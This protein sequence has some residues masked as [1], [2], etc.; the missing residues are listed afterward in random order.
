MR[1]FLLYSENFVI[2]FEISWFDRVAALNS[3]ELHLKNILIKFGFVKFLNYYFFYFLTIARKV[4]IKL[5]CHLFPYNVT[6]S[7]DKIQ[8]AKVENLEVTPNN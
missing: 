2:Y 4:I 3:S 5:N 7:V 1:D 6:Q 8:F